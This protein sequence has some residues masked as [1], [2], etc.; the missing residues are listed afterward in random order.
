MRCQ[1]SLF[2][3]WTVAALLSAVGC[4][5]HFPH[6]ASRPV[7]R[8]KSSEEV[9]AVER[10]RK[11]SQKT[12]KDAEIVRVSH[13]EEGP[14]LGLEEPKG[15]LL[16]ALPPGET[17]KLKKVPECPI[18][19]TRTDTTGKKSEVE[20]KE[21]IVI[22]AYAEQLPMPAQ[23][24][25][26]A[27]VPMLERPTEELA[28][29]APELTLEEAIQLTLGAN[30]D[31]QSA[32]ERTH[33]AGEVL[34]RA[35]AD[36]FPVLAF[37]E[38]YQISDN[39]LR[40]F[41]YL[42]S[43]GISD[44]AT[45]FNPSDVVDNFQSQLR[46]QQEIYSGGLRVARSRSAEADRDA[47]HH[48]LAALQNRIVFQVAESYYRLFQ[49]R[50]LVKVRKESVKQVEEQLKA[51]KARFKAESAVRS[52]VLRV[53]VRLAS[54][55]EAL[56]SAKNQLSLAW[57]LLENVTG[58]PL[59]GRMLPE[60][61]PPAPWKGHLEELLASVQ[62]EVITEGCS[63]LAG[64]LAE[65]ISRRPEISESNSRRE[66][67]EQRVIAAEAGKKA[68]LGFVGDYDVYSG[69]FRSKQTDGNFTIGLSLSVNLFDGGR[70]KSMVRQAEAA[71]R[72]VDAQQRRV[73]LDITLDVRRA[74]LQLKDASERL[75]VAEATVNNAEEILKQVRS[76]YDNQTA[77]LTDLQDAEVGLTDAR[78]RTTNAAAEV[79]VARAALERAI[80]RLNDVLGSPPE[81]HPIM[82][83]AV[84][85]S[86]H[87]A[88][89]VETHP[90]KVIDYA[91][92][93]DEMPVAEKIE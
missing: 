89:P 24:K 12:S 7:A 72:E 48:S 73:R 64:A 35:R 66:A 1:A 55:N 21:G 2:K 11:S 68:T 52:D 25:P 22:A 71:V 6:L 85:R 17:P 44:P 53:E 46:F 36:F 42:L 9:A 13:D 23:V 92:P 61:L 86:P 63:P 82:H 4:T 70:T 67:A 14:S 49:A 76:R 93:T 75:K 88:R 15:P 5:S 32:A 69:D 28:L 57:A 10:S 41:S 91:V 78:V 60:R 58:V 3:K 62:P 79:E 43:Q 74:Y 8:R 31:L 40:K 59:A 30:P 29:P 83:G 80:G 65:A 90:A 45:L 38:N 84:S 34:A 77:P 18:I 26:G 51:V 56:I 27:S 50:E 20:F 54:V 33:Y 16:E 39:P 19:N 87:G 47:A 81:G 37:N